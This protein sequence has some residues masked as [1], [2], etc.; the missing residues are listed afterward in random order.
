MMRFSAVFRL[1]IPQRRHRGRESEHE[2]RI[3]RGDEFGR[4]TVQLDVFLGKQ[5]D[6]A[7]LLLVHDRKSHTGDADDRH[8]EHDVW[9]FSHRARHLSKLI[10]GAS[11][12]HGRTSRVLFV[13][14]PAHRR[15]T[16]HHRRVEHVLA[17]Q[18]VNCQRTPHAHRGARE[19]RSVSKVHSHR[20]GDDG[21][22]ERTQID[23]TVEYR[24]P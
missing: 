2:Q 10:G 19:R 11:A 12:H 20:S 16:C 22:K 3:Q 24:K 17:I 5:H 4:Q 6:R 7:P 23:A 1:P 15:R 9:I 14:V 13:F 18:C 8:G 21:R